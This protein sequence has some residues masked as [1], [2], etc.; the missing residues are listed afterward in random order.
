MNAQLEKT[1]GAYKEISDLNR[2]MAEQKIEK[3]S[4][5][6]SKKSFLR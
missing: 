4:R 5:F 2:S 6:G 3:D 1:T